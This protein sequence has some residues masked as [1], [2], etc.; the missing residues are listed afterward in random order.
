[1]DIYGHSRFTGCLPAHTSKER[2]PQASKIRD[3]GSKGYPAPPVYVLALHNFVSTQNIHQEAIKGLRLEGI[4]VSFFTN[5][6][7][8]GSQPLIECQFSKEF[9]VDNKQAKIPPNFQSKSK[10]PRLCAR[11]K[12]NKNPSTSGQG[13]KTNGRD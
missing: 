5:T 3:T 8:L 6:K 4:G 7:D 11:R 9:R 1:M 2:S 13:S 10:L 12:R